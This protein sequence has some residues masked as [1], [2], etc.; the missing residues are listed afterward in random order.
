MVVKRDTFVVATAKIKKGKEIF[1][2]HR[3]KE[4]EMNSSSG[5]DNN[6]KKG[7]KPAAKK[8]ATRTAAIWKATTVRK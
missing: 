6:S 1:I 5:K 4:N 3:W 7:K 2:N 8:L